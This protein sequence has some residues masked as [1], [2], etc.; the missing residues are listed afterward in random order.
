MTNDNKKWKV[1]GGKIADYDACSLYPSSMYQSDG[2]L[3]GKPNII[4]NTDFNY[5]MGYSGI[6]VKCLI[7]KIG[8]HRQFALCSVMTD[9]GVRDFTNDLV[10]KE[11]YLDKQSIEDLI[12][13][14]EAEL[15]ILNGYYYDEGHNPKI[16]EVIRYLYDT[17]R[18]KKSEGNPIQEVYKL[19]MNSSYGKTI[20]KPIDTET[21][22]V[23]EFKKDKETGKWENFWRKYLGKNYNYIKEFIKVGKEYVVKKHKTIEQHFNNAHIGVEVLSKSKNIMNK[24]I[25]L[26]EDLGLTAY[27]QDTDS[28]H[29]DYDEVAILSKEYKKK[30]G[31]ISYRF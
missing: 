31:T 20:L 3:K 6:F 27:T 30:Y 18:Q 21:D 13:F 1:E 19:I 17:R 28:I 10:G 23:N 29:M 2:F 22:I 16:K 12:E 24:V 8:K 25:C 26:A 4:T 9:K 15:K 11:I 14:Q 7:T 5:C